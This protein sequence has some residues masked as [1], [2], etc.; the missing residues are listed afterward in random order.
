ME[1]REN[2]PRTAAAS[3]TS[4]SWMAGRAALASPLWWAALAVLLVNDHFLKRAGLVPGWLTGKLSDL[5]GL[6]VAPPLLCVLVRARSRRAA[7]ASFAAVAGVFGAVKLSAAAA[8]LL[9]AAVAAFGLRWRIVADPTDLVALAVL[10]LAWRLAMQ[11][12]GAAMWRERA[13]L[14]LGAVACVA[15]SQGGA[16]TWSGEGFVV[17]KTGA[18]L[19]VRLRYYIGFLDCSA[20][21]GRTPRMVDPA[22]FGAGIGFNLAPGETLPVDS[23]SV[24]RAAGVGISGPFPDDDDDRFPKDN[25]CS[26]V[27]IQ[28]EGLRSTLAWWRQGE[29]PRLSIPL[30]DADGLDDFAAG[31]IDIVADAGGLSLAS[32][33]AVQVGAIVRTAEPSGCPSAPTI[34]WTASFPGTGPVVD[35]RGTPDGCTELRC[36]HGDWLTLCVPDGAV[37]FELGDELVSG[38]V[39]GGTLLSSVAGELALV[40]AEWSLDGLRVAGSFQPLPCLGDRT[41]TGSY[42]EPAQLVL[43]TD[44]GPLTLLPGEH[45]TV[46]VTGGTAEVFLGRAERVLAAPVTCAVG[47]CNPLVLRGDVAVLFVPEGGAP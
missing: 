34:E 9:C 39:T 18:D 29:V 25:S 46:A 44:D 6:V 2:S 32:P 21:D 19:V 27:M 3:T 20:L 15:T 47:P 35:L 41:D 13:A 45:A 42:V 24:K 30:D 22:H 43:D 40:H 33:G 26:L 12:R 1:A 5:A 7:R 38:A 17:N 11:E 8:A 10:P 16:A 31:E 37:P 36:E 28:A 4:T 23:T 14:L